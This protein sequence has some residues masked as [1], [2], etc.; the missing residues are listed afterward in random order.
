[1]YFKY[2]SLVVRSL[3]PTSGCDNEQEF[4]SVPECF[5]GWNFEPNVFY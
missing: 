4:I 1:M 5:R 3:W 2:V